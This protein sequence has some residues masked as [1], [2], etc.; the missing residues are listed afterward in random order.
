MLVKGWE[1][2][3][4]TASQ[5]SCPAKIQAS[6]A[7]IKV[8]IIRSFYSYKIAS[9]FTQHNVPKVF[10]HQNQNALGSMQLTK[11]IHKQYAYMR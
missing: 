8:I 1:S 11:H 4:V 10:T 5:R 6:T 9:S 3:M 2:Y 7:V